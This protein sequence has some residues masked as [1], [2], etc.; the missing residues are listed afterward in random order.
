RAACGAA[1]L[2]LALAATVAAEPK[3][4]EILE[5]EN[6]PYTGGEDWKWGFVS[7]DGTARRERGRVLEDGSIEV[8]G[9]W[10]YKDPNGQLHEVA[11]T[12]GKNGYR[13]MSPR[14]ICEDRPGDE[15]C[16]E[17]IQLLTGRRRRRRKIFIRVLL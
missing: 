16:L 10:R 3:L 15:L 14:R 7:Q 1:L 2:L 17:S 11:Y 4:V 12:A 6:D 13:Q 9:A 8:E 5:Q